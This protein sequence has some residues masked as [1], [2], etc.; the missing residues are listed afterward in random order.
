MSTSAQITVWQWFRLPA[1]ERQR[2]AA[3]FRAA[4]AGLEIIREATG[5]GWVPA[6]S[7]HGRALDDLAGRVNDLWPAVPWWCRR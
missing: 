3:E 6:D 7:E 4:V 2:R 1:A 5:G